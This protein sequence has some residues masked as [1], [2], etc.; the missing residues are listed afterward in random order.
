MH[1]DLA[2][3]DGHRLD[4]KKKGKN[5]SDTEN[6]FSLRIGFLCRTEIIILFQRDLM[7]KAVL[8]EHGNSFVLLFMKVINF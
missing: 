6:F 4:L 7:I 8:S 2:G 5:P 1:L 3:N